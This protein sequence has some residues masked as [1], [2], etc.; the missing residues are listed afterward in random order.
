[1]PKTELHFPCS[2]C[3]EIF[4]RIPTSPTPEAQYA[5]IQEWLKEK[6]PKCEKCSGGTWSWTN[7]VAPQFSLKILKEAFDKIK[8]EPPRLESAFIVV[9]CERWRWMKRHGFIQDDSGEKNED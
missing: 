3:Q 2:V 8:N 4:V 7:V 5:E 6:E 1:M 9:S